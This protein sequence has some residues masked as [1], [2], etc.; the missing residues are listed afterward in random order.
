MCDMTYDL[1]LYSQNLWRVAGLALIKGLICN[2]V[3]SSK[4]NFHL[5]GLKVVFMC[6]NND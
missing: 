1:S 4:D 6:E 3:Y 5:L 2:G